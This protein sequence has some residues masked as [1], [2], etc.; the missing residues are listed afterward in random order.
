[1]GYFYKCESKATIIG[2]GGLVRENPDGTISAFYRGTILNNLVPI[3]LTKLCCQALDPSYIFDADNQ[4]CRWSE[5]GAGEDPCANIKPFKVVI[6]PKDNDGVIFSV[7]ETDNEL[8]TLDIS[9]DYLVQFD[10]NTIVDKLTE[11]AQGGLTGDAL[12]EMQ[13]LQ[14]AYD[15]CITTLNTHNNQLSELQIQLSVT[16]YVII[17]ETTTDTG[18]GGELVIDFNPPPDSKDGDA[19][20]FNPL[21]G[22]GEDTGEDTGKIE[23]N[24][25]LP[26][27]FPIQTTTSSYCLTDLGLA[28]WEQIIGVN[29]YAVWL[30]SNGTDTSVYTCN[31]I[32]T[33]IGLDQQSGTLIGTCNVSYTLR[34]EIQQQIWDT[35][36]TIEG[37]NCDGILAQ[38]N[39]L[40][41]SIPCDTVTEILESFNICM[42]LDYINPETNSLETLYEESIFN[43]GTGNLPT[44]LQDTAPNTGLYSSGQTGT[45]NC[46][47]VCTNF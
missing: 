7:E 27:A 4:M 10:C 19:V 28:Q 3:P 11:A 22:T 32:N 21:Q 29:N 30:N 25:G 1:M 6:N 36:K 41:D 44:Y 12:I 40:Q 33:L 45:T 2:N 16:P 20:K 9:F 24:F 23:G 15:D 17:C 47:I 39:E 8:C 18:D 38:I 43:I 5:T 37:I 26:N 34:S 42:T 14:T 35:Q 13:G 46:E 31:H